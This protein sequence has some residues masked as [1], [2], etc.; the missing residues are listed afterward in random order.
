MASSTASSSASAVVERISSSPVA[1]IHKAV[2]CKE[3]GNK[4]YEEGDIKAAMRQWHE[5]SQRQR[6]SKARGA[7]RSKE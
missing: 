2:R 3:E 7:E 4:R 6:Q 5:V 1:N